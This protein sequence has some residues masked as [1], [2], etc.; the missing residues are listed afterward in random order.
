[1]KSLESLAIFPLSDVVL[2]PGATTPL[3][4][5]EPRYR[6]M[7]RDALDGSRE[8][9]MVT[10]RPDGVRDMAGN[11]AIFEIGCLGR[12]THATERPDGTYQILLAGEHRFRVADEDAPDGERLYRCARVELLDDVL[13]ETDAAHERL[14][15]VREDVT[16]LLA[17]L[18]H[19]LGADDPERTLRA[20]AELPASQFVNTLARSIS[21]E[22]AERQRLL[23][24][25]SIIG[26][27][28]TLSDL[29]RFRLADTGLG[30]ADPSRLPN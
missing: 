30:E 9:G 27:C 12:I 29:L 13:P 2:F 4:I 18:I 14:A 22:P 24:T 17:T 20:F 26:R 25:D 15:V 8:I 1:M 16:G 23:E 5:F 21:F 6:Q 19:R 28:E 10:V 11:P 7:T 3:Y